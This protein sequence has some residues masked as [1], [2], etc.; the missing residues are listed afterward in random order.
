MSLEIYQ[1]I[2]LVLIGALVGISMSF[3]GQTGQGVVIPMVL[4]ILNNVMP[5]SEAI[6]YA[7]PISVLNDLVA[8]SA[9]SIGYYK[10]KQFK[11]RKDIAI[12]LVVGVL[13]S[14]IGILILMLTDIGAEFGWFLPVFF[15]CLGIFFLKNGFPTTQSLRKLVMN[16]ARKILSKRGDEE[17]LAR[18]EKKF[19]ADAGQEEEEIKGI[20]P[21]GSRLFYILA[22]LLGLVVGINSGMMGANSGMIIVFILILI[23]GY[24][25]KKGVGTAIILSIVL[26]ASTFLLYQAMGAVFKGTF[27]YNFEI[28]LPLAIGSLITGITASTFIQKLSPK[29]MGR[30]MALAIITVGVVS[31]V[32]FF[33]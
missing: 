11:F 14:I 31:L 18:L 28:S 10:N 30:G 29:A 12:L 8:A 26:C 21:S 25:A 32:F 20:I 19:E 6:L 16:V 27:Y 15:I 23:Y 2:L 9:V 3:F 5:I 1:I 13:G 17:G 33:A 24:P 4:L 22:I 7:I